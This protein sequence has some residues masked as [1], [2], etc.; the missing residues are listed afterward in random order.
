MKLKQSLSALPSTMY[1]PIT[2]KKLN[3]TA[4]K[5]RLGLDTM[6]SVLFVYFRFRDQYL[7][8]NTGMELSDL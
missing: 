5:L 6:S 8:I 1:L 2:D 3:D 4:H 7:W